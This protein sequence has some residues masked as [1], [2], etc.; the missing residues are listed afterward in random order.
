V[1]KHK[2]LQ[3]AKIFVEA[4]ADLTTDGRKVLLIYDGYRSHLGLEALKTLMVCGVLAYALPAHTSG[5]TQPL[6]VNVFS[7]FKQA[8]NKHI[9]FLS[10]STGYALY[11]VFDFAKMMRAAFDAAFTIQN[12]KSA[13]RK[14]GLWPLN[15]VDYCRCR[16]QRTDKLGQQWSA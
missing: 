9:Q 16:C 13:F 8:L 6:D 7:P 12:I 2:F 1:D 4:V 15:S 3:W 5:T 11:D 14:T 10:T